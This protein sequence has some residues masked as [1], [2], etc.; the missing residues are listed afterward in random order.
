MGAFLAAVLLCALLAGCAI[1]SKES[2]WCLPKIKYH[3]VDHAAFA[4]V[5]CAW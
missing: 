2:A 3:R 1:P 4:G 5:R